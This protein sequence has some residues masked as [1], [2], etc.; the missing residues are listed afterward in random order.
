M[1][2]IEKSYRFRVATAGASVVEGNVDWTETGNIA[3][4]GDIGGQTVHPTK[5]QT[6]ARPWS[7][8]IV[9]LNEAITARL[10]NANGRA[11]LL[12]RLADI[13]ESTNGGSTW[14]VLATARIDRVEMVDVAAFR[15][16]MQDER[17]VERV[18]TIFTGS[19]TTRVLPRG[20]AA[21]WLAYAGARHTTYQ[22]NT[23]DT[24][25]DVSQYVFLGNNDEDVDPP[26]VS[27]QIM[28]LLEADVVDAPANYQGNFRTLRV[29]INGVDREILSINGSP[30]QDPLKKLREEP[31]R[32]LRFFDVADYEDTPGF[33]RQ[34]YFHMG[35]RD[36]SPELPLHI[37]GL[38]GVDPF[39]FVKDLYDGG[40]QGTNPATVR[41][42][43]ARF[44]AYDPATN[45]HGL[46][47]NP[48]F[49]RM[50]WRITSPAN[51]AEWLEDNIYGPLGV[52]P[53]INAAGEVSPRIALMPAVDQIADPDTL[54]ELTAAN[55]AAPHPGWVN[56]G[57][58]LITVV[59]VTFEYA[60]APS[61]IRTRAA[62]GLFGSLFGTGILLPTEG[63]QDVG[64]DLLVTK[65]LKLTKEHDRA[66]D[67]RAVHPVTVRGIHRPLN[68]W[69]FLNKLALDLFERFGDG[70]IYTDASPLSGAAS[71]PAE[72]DW[73]RINL[74]GSYPAL[75]NQSRTGSRIAQILSKVYGA[76][77]VRFELLEG[78][79]NSQPMGTPT[80]SLA[81]NA[82]D[83]ENA[84]DVTVSG[85]EA[86]GSYE[87]HFAVATLEPAED[88]SDWQFRHARG[89]AVSPATSVTFTVRGIPAGSTVWGRARETA[90]G[91]ISSDWS[92]ADSQ[93]T[94]GLS[95]PTGLAS[96]GVVGDEAT[97]S[98]TVGEAAFDLMVD[99]ILQSGG[100]QVVAP[101]RLP[102]G[103][104]RWRFTGLALS[105][106]Y[107]ARVWHVDDYGGAS[108]KTTVNF[109]TTGTA[110]TLSK[111]RSIRVLVGVT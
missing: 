30:P 58:E 57:R 5:G 88:S 69:A 103:S 32:W 28:D 98:W 25:N 105:T 7:V 95:A 33:A 94:T 1:T 75:Q 29:S 108:S 47:D 20:L 53:F 82:A 52:V 84:I 48:R 65:Q 107:T 9:D 73:V 90:V 76:D 31:R 42:E 27:E 68:Q 63:G 18:T 99:L 55:L 44:T 54:P 22:V 79:P 35:S 60:T 70:P 15:F 26:T 51:M 72:G 50:H 111:P 12:R 19:N 77:G 86:G 40:Y 101:F 41:Y 71:A 61:F 56:D 8:E 87:A 36:P 37:G 91:R 109:S 81:A 97:I 74:P 14:T 38:S 6:T 100:A 96:S 80:I 23:V 89:S 49:P 110:A 78:G 13:A 24:V 45:P 39:T 16:T 92:T 85:L 59:E 102:A 67:F 93:A 62:G 83:P 64:G 66:A 43:A 34:V 46:V 11:H 17:S 4:V 2:A 21:S 3:T 104:A 10:S 106:G